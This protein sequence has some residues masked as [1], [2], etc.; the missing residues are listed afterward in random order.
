YNNTIH[1]A[2]GLTPNEA[3]DVTNLSRVKQQHFSNRIEKY[4]KLFKEK[5]L[6]KLNLHDFVLIEDTIHKVKGQPKFGNIGEVIGVLNNDTYLIADRKNIL[7]R[8][9]T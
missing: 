1:N 9:I 2:T 6:I 4:R 7:K 8:H 3:M 5:Q